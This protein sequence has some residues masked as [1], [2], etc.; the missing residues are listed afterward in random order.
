MEVKLTKNAKEFLVFSYFGI[1]E[2]ELKGKDAKDRIAMKCAERAYRDMCRTLTFSE[3]IDGKHKKEIESK[4]QE[5]RKAICKLIVDNVFELLECDEDNF[6]N[7]HAELCDMIRKEAIKFQGYSETQLLKKRNEEKDDAVFYHGQAQKW[8]NMTI[9]YMRMLGCYSEP[10]NG[11]EKKLH[12]PV[13]E[14]I[15]KAAKNKLNINTV[16]NAW[17]KWEYGE[18][19]NFQNTLRDAL[20]KIGKTRCEWEEKAW[21]DMAKKERDQEN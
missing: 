14:Y 21:I 18:Y 9:K 15:L 17:S 10:M 13:D 11:F 2:D 20:A 12:I 6:D 8:L 7:K 4:R 1:T 5:F 16:G 19:K 3:K